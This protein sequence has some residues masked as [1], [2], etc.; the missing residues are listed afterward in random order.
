MVESSSA[1]N[2]QLTRSSESLCSG[3]FHKA[4]GRTVVMGMTTRTDTTAPLV[5][6]R[7][8]TQDPA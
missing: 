4:T 1:M 2:G 7:M 8:G 6:V 5:A 3:I